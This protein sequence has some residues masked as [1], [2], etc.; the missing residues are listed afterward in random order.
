MFT[1]Y[2]PPPFHSSATPK[3]MIFLKTKPTL[4][5]RSEETRKLEIK[6]HTT[7]FPEGSHR[8]ISPHDVL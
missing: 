3:H 6:I 7:F 5:P 8:E 4:T 2:P 1:L